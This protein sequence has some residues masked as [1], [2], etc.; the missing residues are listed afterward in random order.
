MC[1]SSICH[2]CK[3]VAQVVKAQLAV[4]DVCHVAVVCLATLIVLGPD[5][6]LV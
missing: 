4:C 2:L 1:T 5:K 6:E 3:V